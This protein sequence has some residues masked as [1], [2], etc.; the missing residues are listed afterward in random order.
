MSHIPGGY[1][2]R[3]TQRLEGGSGDAS[4]GTQK[5]QL[6]PIDVERRIVKKCGGRGVLRDRSG[7][8]ML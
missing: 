5:R 7:I 2:S 1:R 4:S 6:V 3:D 8:S